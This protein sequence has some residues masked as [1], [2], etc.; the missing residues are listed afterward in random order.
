MMLVIYICFLELTNTRG[1][2]CVEV[3]VHPRDSKELNVAFII[4]LYRWCR[5]LFDGSSYIFVVEKYL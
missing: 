4:Q 2:S 5:H 3:V 1:E